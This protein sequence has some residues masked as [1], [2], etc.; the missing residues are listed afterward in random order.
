[1]CSCILQVLGSFIQEREE[2]GALRSTCTAIYIRLYTNY[3]SIR[4]D[5]PGAV[6]VKVMT[7]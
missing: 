2:E 1:M 7:T 3:D 6:R 5:T 4:P